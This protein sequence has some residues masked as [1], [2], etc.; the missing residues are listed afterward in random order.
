MGK[1]GEGGGQC[2]RGQGKIEYR[3]AEPECSSAE[4]S[5]NNKR[6]AVPAGGRGKSKGRE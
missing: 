3:G 2:G 4:E 5:G 6:H 1:Q